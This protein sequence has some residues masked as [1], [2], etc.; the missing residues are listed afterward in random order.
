MARHPNPKRYRTI[1]YLSSPLTAAALAAG[2]SLG[3]PIVEGALAPVLAQGR[4]EVSAEF[5]AALQPYGRWEHHSR[6]GEVWAP[7]NRSQD[8]RPYS[9]GCWSYTDDW[10]WYWVS[11][12]EED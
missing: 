1:A 2:L 12:Q 5:R 6:W 3:A 4:V 10:G 11:D 8:W 7:A 9:A